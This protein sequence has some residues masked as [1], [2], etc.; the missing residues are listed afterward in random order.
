MRVLTTFFVLVLLL[1]P[2]PY[3][4]AE[5]AGFV[6]DIAQRF[7]DSEIDLQRSRS[8]VPFLPLATL[9]TNFYADTDVDL[10]SGPDLQYDLNMISQY[11]V[12]PLLVSPRDALFVGEYLSMARFDVADDG[13]DDFD[14]ATVALPLGWLRQASED[15]QI[16][17]FVM[18]MAHRSTL[19]GSGWN[20][21]YLGGAF[22]RYTQTDRLWWLYGIYADVSP[23][24]DF[25][26]PYVGASWSINENWT[27]S[28]VLP[29]PSLLYSPD[30]NWLFRA[31][32]SP[33]GA[34]WGI[35]TDSG[36]VGVNYD[37]WDID[38][39]IERRIAGNIWLGFSTGIGGLRG[40]RFDGSGFEAPDIDIGSSGFISLSLGFRPGL[41]DDSMPPVPGM[42]GGGF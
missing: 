24:D 2:S 18:P 15:W 14:V 35:S 31:G 19:E 28:A 27:L 26:I 5:E 21:Q 13:V 3:L 1:P 8:N 17:G 41:G 33:S 30:G 36:D 20:M 10:S 9:N 23:E 29:W 6:R 25:V 38:V 22:G 7:L 34:S 16:G 32:I 40:L 42:P 12:L 11:A 39:G 37:A 4:D